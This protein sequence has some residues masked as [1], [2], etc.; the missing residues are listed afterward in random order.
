MFRK[1]HKLYFYYLYLSDGQTLAVWI[2]LIGVGANPTVFK[3]FDN[4]EVNFTYWIPNQPVQ[5]TEEL[6][7][8]FYSGEVCFGVCVVCYPFV[9][10]CVMS[11]L[12]VSHI[13]RAVFWHVSICRHTAGKS[14]TAPKSCLLCARGKER[15]MSPHSLGVLWWV[16]P[17]LNIIPL[18]SQC[19]PS[20][21][22]DSYETVII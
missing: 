16:V 14:V 18:K 6:S 1:I 13:P 12:S 22:I 4:T 5:P 8:V 19:F 10:E 15:L 2:G 17:K 9:L 3:W 7:C 11:F 21:F 20:I